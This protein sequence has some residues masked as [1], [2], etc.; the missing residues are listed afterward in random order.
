MG[1]REYQSSSGLLRINRGISERGVN[2][3]KGKGWRRNKK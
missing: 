1:E 2:V 3:R